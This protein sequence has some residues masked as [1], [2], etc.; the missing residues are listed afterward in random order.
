MTRKPLIIGHR[1][2]SAIAPENTL[3]AFRRALKD[4]AD[5][6]ECD[7][8]LSRDGVP[9]VIHDTDLKRTGLIEE[10]VSAL[11]AAELT[12]IEVGTWFNLR[13]PNKAR[14]DFAKET[15]PTLVQFL[16]LMH[17]NDKLFYVEMKCDD[18]NETETAEAVAKVI[19]QFDTSRIIV[20]SFEHDSIVAIKRLCPKIK[21]AALFRP[22]PSR[23]F[24]PTNKLIE[25][26][27]AIKADE[28]S[29]HYSLA[30]KSALRKAR[31]AG[32]PTVI[33][34]ADRLSWVKRAFKH[35]IYAI[36]TNNPARLLNQRE[37]LLREDFFNL[38][39]DISNH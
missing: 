20:K 30:T 32:L 27:L 2:A 37:K 34:T 28:L 13:Y 15:I 17:D 8:R 9:M 23:L 29:I 4:G 6:I 10:K 24:R 14:R 35:G 1:G 26:T 36:I 18:G 22:K 11:T 5:G 3:V 16:E 7:V 31:L 33:W 21:T 39:E 12:K 19:K 38:T 25:P